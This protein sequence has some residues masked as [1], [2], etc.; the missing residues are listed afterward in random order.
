[1][2]QFTVF[3]GSAG[4]SWNIPLSSLTI[5]G[6]FRMGKPDSVVAIQTKLIWKWSSRYIQGQHER[7]RSEIVTTLNRWCEWILK[8]F[9][10]KV[11]MYGWYCLRVDGRHDDTIRL[12][13]FSF[14]PVPWQSKNCHCHLGQ[15]MCN[16]S[17]WQQQCLG[18]PRKQ[19]RTVNQQSA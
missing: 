16:V 4:C 7:V 6:C 19:K 9:T 1:M 8:P 18:W 11:L 2:S 14:Q 17:L 13:A 12:T 3:L 10:T 5:K 15:R